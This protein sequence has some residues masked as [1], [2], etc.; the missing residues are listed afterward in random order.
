MNGQR[1]HHQSPRAWVNIF[2]LR[3]KGHQRLA[4]VFGMNARLTRRLMHSAYPGATRGFW[5]D[6]AGHK[7]TSTVGAHIAQHVIN[8]VSAKRALIGADA[9]I[10]CLRGQVAITALAIWAQFQ[11]GNS[12][13]SHDRIN[14]KGPPIQAAPI[15][16]KDANVILVNP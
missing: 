8:A 5:P 9:R 1:L 2:V 3:G 6:G 16:S 12:L 13:L 10:G 15:T 4:G 7:T 14:E 11:H